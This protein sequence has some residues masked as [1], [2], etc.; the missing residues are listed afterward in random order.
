MLLQRGGP[1]G[2]L[3]RQISSDAVML[4]GLR[5]PGEKQQ[6]TKWLKKMGL[7][8]SSWLSQQSPQDVPG[9]GWK[10]VG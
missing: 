6:S 9:T 10:H 8:I 5:A 4:V 1:G 7:D 3:M 2:N